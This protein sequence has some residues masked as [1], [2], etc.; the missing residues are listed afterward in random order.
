[1]DSGAVLTGVAIAIMAAQAD[2]LEGFDGKWL[3]GPGEPMTTDRP[4]GY[5]IISREMFPSG[6]FRQ[7]HEGRSRRIT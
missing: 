7:A 4:A 1:M 5:L 6:T 3:H 2:P